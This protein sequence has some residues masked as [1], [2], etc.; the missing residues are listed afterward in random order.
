MGKA[1]ITI[2]PAIKL[3]DIGKK[4]GDKKYTDAAKKAVD[5][6]LNMQ[7]PEAGDYWETPLHAANPLAALAVR[8]IG[9]PA[10]GNNPKQSFSSCAGLAVYEQ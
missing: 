3:F 8:V 9:K 5:F 10:C 4:T 6:C 2:N 1:D 7:R